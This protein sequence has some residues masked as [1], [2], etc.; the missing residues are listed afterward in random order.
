M[1]FIALLLVS[2]SFLLIML[3]I[4]VLYRFSNSSTEWT[5]KLQHLLS[6]LLIT[7]FP[8]IFSSSTEVITLAA[9][10]VIVLVIF[11]K[12]KF[13]TSL[14]DV[15]RKS[16]GEFYLLIT[17]VILTILAQHRYLEY[18]FISILTLTISDLLAALVGTTY[19]KMTY[20][21]KG[22]TKSWEG[23]ITCF[24]STFLI[25]HLSL[26]F[27][28]DIDHLRSVIIA[29]QIA[30]IVS[31][32]EAVSRKGIDNLLIPLTTFFLLLHLSN[33]STFLIINETIVLFVAGIAFLLVLN[34][35]QRKTRF[36]IDSFSP[37]DGRIKL[38]EK[39]KSEIY[40]MSQTIETI[41]SQAVCLVAMKNKIPQAA[42][43]IHKKGDFGLIGNY[44][45]LNENAGVYLLKLKVLGVQKIVGPMNNNTWQRYRLALDDVNPFFLGE[46][47]NPSGY[48]NYF[49]KA[50]FLVAERYES[51]IVTNLLLRKDSYL[52]LETRMERLGMTIKPLQMET[53]ESI[54]KEIYEMSVY[55]FA[56]NRF[57]EF[58]S[59]EEFC[60][61]YQRIKPLLD[62]DFVQLA[63]DKQNHLIGYAFAY[64]DA[65]DPSRIILKTLATNQT[66]RSSGAGVYLYDRIHWIASQKG[67][68]AVIHA[69]MHEKHNSVKLSKAM[70]SLPFRDYALYET[71]TK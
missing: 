65:Y 37:D 30:L 64:P 38:F 23:S 32:V 60:S 47:K 24:I 31:I 71:V 35:I 1:N 53:F 63:Y 22:H 66:G 4:E 5:R 69:L 28:S 34:F 62:P 39:L 57:Y 8:W 68:K 17:A 15:E 29:L 48:H 3:S 2:F 44:E 59:F 12:L 14:H 61:M 46:P 20:T 42:L 19:K 16:Y 52:R 50:G 26:S 13:L 41:H 6:G 49:L 67:K 58:I 7:S 11:R 45:A 56:E 54:L 9:V 21:V 33:S 51:R 36:V 55:A 40:P 70:E 27:L 18:Y 25:V 10:M 43:T